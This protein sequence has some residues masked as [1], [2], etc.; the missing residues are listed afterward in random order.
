MPVPSVRHRNVTRFVPM[1]DHT[2]PSCRRRDRRTVGMRTAHPLRAGSRTVRSK[3][4]TSSPGNPT[5]KKTSC[6]ERTAPI[7]RQVGALPAGNK[8][9]DEPAQDERQSGTDVNAHRVN[10]HGG[11]PLLRPEI[12]RDQ[13]IGRRR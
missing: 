3:S 8:L 12:I 6:Q 10:A 2:G 7:T 4:A 13:R 11:R 5:T 1:Y 9:H